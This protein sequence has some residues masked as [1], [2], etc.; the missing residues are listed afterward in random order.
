MQIILC[1]KILFIYKY[2]NKLKKIIV[3]LM[4]LFHL[5]VRLL[6]NYEKEKYINKKRK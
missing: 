1:N 3:I 6:Y 5:I 4:F 2:N